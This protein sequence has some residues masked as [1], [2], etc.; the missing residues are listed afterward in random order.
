MEDILASF[1]V[2]IYLLFKHGKRGESNN[3]N[4]SEH[5]HFYFDAQIEFCVKRIYYTMF[6]GSSI[7]K[8]NLTINNYTNESLEKQLI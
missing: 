7:T 6:S 8:Y 1:D 2:L 3:E 4:L 5:I